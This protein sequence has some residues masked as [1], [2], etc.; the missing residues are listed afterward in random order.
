M[1]LAKII[2]TI[3]MREQIL[4]EW[5][6]TRI[7][8]LKET[9]PQKALRIET[10]LFT[11]VSIGYMIDNFDSLFL[12]QLFKIIASSRLAHTVGSGNLK[13]M[14]AKWPEWKSREGQF[15]TSVIC[16]ADPDA[17][18]GLLRHYCE[19]ETYHFTLN[20]RWKGVMEG[21]AFLPKAQR[22]IVA[23][24]LV[25][26]CLEDDRGV[27]SFCEK[28]LADVFKLAWE[29]E[30]PQY[31]ALLH[32]IMF[33]SVT[34]NID[35]YID[36]L[37]DVLNIIGL[38]DLEYSMLDNMIDI[39]YEEWPLDEDALRFY[40]DDT[41]PYRTITQS[42]DKV[43]KKHYNFISALFKQYPDVIK[44]KRI[45]T[46]LNE[47]LNDKKGIN[48]LRRIK[49][50][51]YFYNMILASLMASVRKEK[52]DL[53]GPDGN[54][55]SADQ[56][57]RLLALDIKTN[58][59]QNILTGYLKTQDKAE[60]VRS[61]TD[62]YYE[63]IDG[64]YSDAHL[65]RLM[66]ALQ[67]DEF[68]ELLIEGLDS[69]FDYEDITVEPLPDTAE[70][71][72]LN[73][74]V[75]AVDYL[76]AHF[77]SLEE[78]T[79]Q[80]A[81]LAIA[82]KVGGGPKAIC[83]PLFVD[84]Y[85]DVFWK[86]E[87]EYLLRTLEAFADQKYLKRLKPFV[88]KG[89]YLIDNAYLLIS[90]LNQRQSTELP[91]LLKQYKQKRKE[92]TELIDSVL[93][94]SQ[95][96]DAFFKSEP[97]PYVD[98]ELECQNCHH[99]YVYRLE[100]V[101]FSDSFKPYITQEIECLNCHKKAGFQFTNRGNNA[102]AGEL[103]RAK[104]RQEQGL[105]DVFAGGPLQYIQDI[106]A[107]V[108]GET[109]DAYEAIDFYKRAID[110]NPNNANNYIGLG[111]LYHDMEQYGK[112]GEY[113]NQAISIDPSYIQAYYMQA[114]A[115]GDTN[116]IFDLLSQGLPYLKSFKYYQGA[117]PDKREF[118]RSYCHAYNDMRN[119]TGSDAPLLEIPAIAQTGKRLTQPYI[120][121]KKIGRNEPC[122]CGSGK[123][124]KKCCIDK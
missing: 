79:A 68:L 43:N 46:V 109:T 5:V 54:I 36:D 37:A 63:T 76:T 56:A 28:H 100:K 18:V 20:S 55:L 81:A 15:A 65:F 71:A 118:V 98:A 33:L 123:K 23:S 97:E 44:E 52:F 58:P 83:P 66:G 51:R 110:K 86:L 16:K 92:Q 88:N 48:R 53:T 120:R 1:N 49:Q 105:E 78:E 77:D 103:V 64:Y 73:Y 22:R 50:H 108:S 62:I 2:E 17:A 60:V 101:Y 27:K 119:K 8:D 122:P 13:K 12:I 75:R 21:I 10:Q 4:A 104:F 115:G 19:F 70:K 14:I 94:N 32:R 41:I 74:G 124:Y 87:N 116:K 59:A 121:E 9:D 85:F 91:P 61:L 80:Y 117:G 102:I 45:K 106:D 40:Y 99:R 29:S 47:L 25:D 24:M 34:S 42:V 11:D 26:K 57:V 67:Y 113:Y 7:E 38:G 90:L 3:D 112:A 107:P 72:L 89:Q 30:H 93:N 6:L 35:R 39:E 111:N 69:D 96:R 82:R 31:K 84:K 95:F 114:K